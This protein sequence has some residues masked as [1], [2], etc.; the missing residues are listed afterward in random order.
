MMKRFGMMSA[1]LALTACAST[2]HPKDPLEGFNRVV[3]TFN[4]VLDQTAVKPAAT[5][6]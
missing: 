1:A 4:D 2:G 5:F 6:Y 3:F